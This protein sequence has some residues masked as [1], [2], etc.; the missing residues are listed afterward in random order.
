M[1]RRPP[2]ST[3]FPYTTL[4]RSDEVIP[5]GNQVPQ[6]TAVVAERHPAVHATGALLAQLLHRP[7]EQE[8]AV[9]ARPLHRVPLGKVVTLDLQEAPELAHQAPV[10]PTA[11]SGRGAA[12]PP[13]LAARAAR[14][15]S[16]SAS[17]PI[18]LLGGP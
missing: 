4:F 7:R 9:V 5:V 2:R 6:R 12:N 3:L 10:S 13:L 1:I 8:L 14:A 17:S 18:S 16:P 15:S 11:S